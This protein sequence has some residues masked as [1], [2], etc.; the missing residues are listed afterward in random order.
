MD[1]K[2]YHKANAIKQ[3]ITDTEMDEK[4]TLKYV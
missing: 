2:M 3:Y 1:I 4:K